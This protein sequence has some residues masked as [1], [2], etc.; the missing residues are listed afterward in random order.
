MRRGY[1]YCAGT[2][3]RVV[4]RR[5]MGLYKC[6]SVSGFPVEVGIVQPWDSEA[7]RVII[8]FESV[9]SQG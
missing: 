6:T 1:A 3:T 4:S 9:G 7:S 2:W 8:I 5:E